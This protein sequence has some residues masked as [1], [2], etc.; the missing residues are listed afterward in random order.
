M[1][2]RQV[3]DIVKA[4]GLRIDLVDGRPVIRCTD[5]TA[6]T[7]ALLSVLKIHREK[8]IEALKADGP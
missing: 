3:L 7:D 4:R 2:T 1:S 5:R 6:V 8:I